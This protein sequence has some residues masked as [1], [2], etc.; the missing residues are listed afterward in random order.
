[1]VP[2]LVITFFDGKSN[3]F[4]LSHDS[5]FLTAFLCNSRLLTF[6][7]HFCPLYNFIATIIIANAGKIKGMIKRLLQY[8]LGHGSRKS[9]KSSASFKIVDG[10]LIES[11]I[12][13]LDTANNT[14]GGQGIRD[15]PDTPGVSRKPAARYSGQSGKQKKLQNT[16]DTH[17]EGKDAHV[18]EPYKLNASKGRPHALSG[19]FLTLRSAGRSKRTIEGYASDIRGWERY[20]IENKIT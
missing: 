12:I 20:V 3:T 10:K 14:P 1:M 13:S 2:D 19:F 6:Y 17:N 7:Y 5:P 15:D 18:P 4:F 9:A 8:T 16:P 11:E